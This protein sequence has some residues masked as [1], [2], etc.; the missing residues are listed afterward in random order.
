MYRVDSPL[1]SGIMK[2]LGPTG[3]MTRGTALGTTE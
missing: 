2:P 1:Y 3:A